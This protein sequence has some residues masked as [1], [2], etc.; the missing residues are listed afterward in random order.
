M[1]AG[2]KYFVRMLLE[3]NS[4]PISIIQESAHKMWAHN[5]HL[6]Q[7]NFEFQLENWLRESQNMKGEGQ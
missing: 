6:I 3:L 7:L 5:Q 4:H 2:F 1:V